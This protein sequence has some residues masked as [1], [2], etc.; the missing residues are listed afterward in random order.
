MHVALD[1]D[2]YCSLLF[3]FK[4]AEPKSVDI[5]IATSAVDMERASEQICTLTLERD[6]LKRDLESAALDEEHY[7]SLL[8]E[9]EQA[10]HELEQVSSL[11]DELAL[12]MDTIDIQA[13]D[14]RELKLELAGFGVGREAPSG[15]SGVNLMD[16]LG[17]Q[18]CLSLE[19]EIK[20]LSVQ[21]LQDSVSRS[22]KSG[23]VT[24]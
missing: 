7:R 3:Q 22:Q 12:A 10:K 24:F 1:V 8:L 13:S 19:D 16:E 6:R 11:R 15:G 5:S 23:S 20:Q 2:Q 18:E 9:L 17:G 14:L 21:A 4:Q